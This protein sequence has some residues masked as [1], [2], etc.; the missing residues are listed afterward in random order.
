MGLYVS[1][2]TGAGGNDAGSDITGGRYQS[3]NDATDGHRNVTLLPDA[4]SVHGT[5]T[6]VYHAAAAVTSF[7]FG[8]GLEITGSS[9]ADP[10]RHTDL[11]D[12]YYAA[13]NVRQQIVAR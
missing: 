8:H 11:K 9:A 7:P 2:Y 10:D 5:Y 13:H 12:Q 3:S 4:Y 6:S 1:T